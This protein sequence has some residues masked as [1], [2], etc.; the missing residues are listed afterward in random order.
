M[1][2]PLAGVRVVEIG[3]EIQGPFAGLLLSDLG[4]DVIKIENR[5]TG[6]LSR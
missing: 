4:A 5:T 3:Q 1:S 6:D 2:Q